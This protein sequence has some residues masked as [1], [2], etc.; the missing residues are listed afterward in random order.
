MHVVTDPADLDKMRAACRDAAKV[1][2][3]LT[4]YVKAGV[5]TG[6][7]DQLVLD[8][9]KDELNVKSA[10]VGYAPQGYPPFPGAICTS[11]N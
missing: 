10:T 2:D 4:P 8:Y 7:L 6:E 11:V 3:Y 5:T 9:I 1:L